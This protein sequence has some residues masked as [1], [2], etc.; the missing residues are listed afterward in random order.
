LE[1][2]PGLHKSFKN[3]TSVP[4]KTIFLDKSEG[5]ECILTST[6]E[7]TKK[8][9]YS[10]MKT[11]QSICSSTIEGTKTK[12]SICSSTIEGAKTK[13]S[14]RSSTIDDLTLLVPPASL[15]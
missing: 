14:I 15:Y 5:K 3:T 7:G 13:Q 11:N 8:R 6:N 1:S 4:F 12:R 9:N 10:G 2:I